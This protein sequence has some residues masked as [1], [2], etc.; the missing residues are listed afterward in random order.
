LQ[1]GVQEKIQE[2]QNQ[3]R[4]VTCLKKTKKE[5]HVKA[6]SYLIYCLLQQFPNS[7]C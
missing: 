7:G 3:V 4:K 1:C 5:G 6:Q 2:T